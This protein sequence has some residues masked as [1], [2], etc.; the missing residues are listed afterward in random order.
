LIGLAHLGLGHQAE[1]QRAFQE[2]AAL[3]PYHPLSR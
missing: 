3:N 2:V 1:S